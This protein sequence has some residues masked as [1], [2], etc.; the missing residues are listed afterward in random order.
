[1]PLNLQGAGFLR[2]PLVEKNDMVSRDFKKYLDNLEDHILNLFQLKVN[3][4]PPVNKEGAVAFATNGL[5]Q[6]EAPGSGTGVPVYYSQGHWRR[7][8]DD[9]VVAA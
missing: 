7:Y 9:T 5:K 1:M 6:G 2:Q 4:L 3:Q 8:S